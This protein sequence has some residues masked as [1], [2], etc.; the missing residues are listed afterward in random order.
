[1]T[2]TVLCWVWAVK[3]PGTLCRGLLGCSTGYLAKRLTPV[4]GVGKGSGDWRGHLV[5]S[6]PMEGG[7]EVKSSL[8]SL[9]TIVG[10]WTT[11][12]LWADA[13]QG[14]RRGYEYSAWALGKTQGCYRASMM[15]GKQNFVVGGTMDV[16]QTMIKAGELV[17]HLWNYFYYIQNHF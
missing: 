8:R 6:L 14:N 4:S 7:V 16:Q 17:Q 5:A 3:W 10:I 2:W 13:G 15:W 1:M 12:I 9:P 11:I